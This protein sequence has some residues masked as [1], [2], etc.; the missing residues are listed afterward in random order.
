[1]SIKNN[2][3]QGLPNYS[4]RGFEV[5]KVL[6]SL[7]KINII[8]IV[9]A[10]LAAA[11]IQANGSVKTDR[12]KTVIAQKLTERLRVD[13][14][15]QSVEVKLGSVRDHEVSKSR[16]D[17]NGQAFA[18]VVNDKT[19]LP[20][21]F[22]ANVNLSNQN[23]ESLDYQFVEA[24]SEFAPSAAEDN[25]MK[26]LMT[27]ISKDFETTNIVISIDGF[28]TARLTPTEMKY[29]GIGEV[30]IGDFE[31]RK[32]KFNVVLESQNNTATKILYDV[33]K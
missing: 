30:R 11:A 7:I 5:M 19:E 4:A 23:I 27:K 3:A 26:E 18:V 6:Y 33:Q 15:D 28:E 20:F 8:I 22:T 14:A 29:E 31:W 17:F 16:V 12:Y 24:G 13:L 9:L 10:I 32:I 21:Q 1:M 25:L 2:L